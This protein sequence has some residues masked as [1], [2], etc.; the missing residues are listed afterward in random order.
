MFHLIYYNLIDFP[1]FLDSFCIY[2]INLL[3]HPVKRFVL[4]RG[5]SLNT[6]FH[7]IISTIHYISALRF[8]LNLVKLSE[9]QIRINLVEDYAL[10]IFKIFD[11]FDLF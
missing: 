10:L 11:D 3:L 7:S 2:N 6:L 1:K 4:I 8:K 5:K 9:F